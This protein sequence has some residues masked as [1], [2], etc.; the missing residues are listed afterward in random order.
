M[1]KKKNK[2]IIWFVPSLRKKIKLPFYKGYIVIK[3]KNLWQR[4]FLKFFGFKT[5]WNKIKKNRNIF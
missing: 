5:W 1:K 2:T 3:P 4:N